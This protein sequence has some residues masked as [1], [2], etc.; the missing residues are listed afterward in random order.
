[1]KS[2]CNVL[3]NFAPYKKKLIDAG[4]VSALAAVIESSKD[5]ADQSTFELASNFLKPL[6]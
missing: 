4:A 6:L 3:Q 5:D 1:V 2:H